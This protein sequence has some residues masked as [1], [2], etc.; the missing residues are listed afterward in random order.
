M[1]LLL[2]LAHLWR[3]ADRRGAHQKNLRHPLDGLNATAGRR[4]DAVK[5][6]IPFDTQV[7]PVSEFPVKIEP[8][9]FL[10]VAIMSLVICFL[11]NLYPSYQASRKDP[12]EALRYE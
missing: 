10:G 4:G 12:V 5:K 1:V 2:N 6:L 7:Y 9:Y 8:L 11:A 3:L